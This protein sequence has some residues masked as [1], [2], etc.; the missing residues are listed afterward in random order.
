MKTITKIV[1]SALAAFVFAC[2]CFLAHAAGLQ[3]PPDGGYPGANTAEG[4]N[5]LFNLTSG[6]YNTAIGSFSLK[7]NITGNLNTGLGAGVLFANTADENTAIGAG[8]LLSNM[9]G[10]GNTADGA[11]ALFSNTIG[12]GN[13]ATGLQALFSNANGIRNTANGVFALDHNISGSGNTA[14]GYQAL[15]N[16]TAD[17]NTAIGNDSLVFNTNGSNNTAT[18][19]GAL[20]SNISGQY[21]TAIGFQALYSNTDGHNNA[22]TGR[23]ALHNNASGQENTATGVSALYSNTNGKFNTATGTS[24]LSNNS[25][26]T[27]N[28]ATGYRA[29]SDN[30]GSYNAALGY[31]AG[32][33]LTTGNN[34][35]DIGN[36]GVS[37]ESNTI[38]IGT[39][40]TQT[41]TY[42][43]GIF[44]ATVTDGA[45]VIV[46]INGHLGTVVS[47][48]RFKD[49]IKP[50]DKASAVILA[51]KPVT[52]R[53]KKERDP[54]RIP[55]FGLVAED[56]EKTDPDL[57]IRDRD[58]KPYTVRYDAVNAMLLN[59]FL[60]EHN[61][62]LEERHRVEKLEATVAGLLATVK[63][64]AAKI[65][66]VSAHIQMDQRAT[67]VALS[68]P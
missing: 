10:A 25:T 5:A 13:T 67:N 11:F 33:N 34:N 58:G 38:R 37:A 15:A 62:S 8:A 65:Q 42:I 18:G 29:L 24:A 14:I 4:D 48:R 30:T 9:T 2:L 17:G 66:K 46:D 20:L 60:R 43:A 61:A 49:E 1:H 32:A 52:F 53:Y 64:Q 55:Q 27:G 41:A 39:Q 23:F 26:S 40:G 57:V 35:I 12:T 56:V 63:E 21:N 47:S 7:S 50:M 3:P 51:L 22:A 36:I 28:T 6:T 19:A 44:G 59:E 54:K 31:F 16:N 45:P 68:R